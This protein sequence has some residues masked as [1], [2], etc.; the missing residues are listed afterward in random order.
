MNL[1]KITG[2]VLG[3]VLIF[4]VIAPT[5][6]QNATTNEEINSF[7]L[8]WP[9]V[10]GR[11]IDDPLYP[12]KSLKEKIRGW[13]IFGKPQKAEYAITLATKRVVEAEKL[14]GDGK[15]ELAE[16]TLDKALTQLNEAERKIKRAGGSLDNFVNEINNKLDNLEKFIPQ[17]SSQNEDASEKLNFVLEK[18]KDLNKKV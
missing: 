13:F 10:A 11:T 9:I 8:F 12:L 3:L 6:A 4:G 18:V 15:K 16:K 1:K 17:L 14:L 7:E 2:F 5:F